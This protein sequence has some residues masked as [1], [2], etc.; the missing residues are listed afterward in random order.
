MKARNPNTGNFEKLYVKALDSM[1]IG[2][3]VDFD[4]SVSDIPD[5]W[6]EVSGTNYTAFELYNNTS[7]TT[8][9]IQLSDSVSNYSYIEILY[10]INVLPNICGNSCI[11][12]PNVC[13]RAILFTSIP[14]NAN[15]STNVRLIEISGTSITNVYENYIN[16][17]GSTTDTNTS[18]IK[19]YKV[20]GY[21]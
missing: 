10:F 12:D 11:I 17:I 18:D 13:S 5:G 20:I 9:T 14:T 2:T 1:P 15:W 3:E 6:E 8:G 19:I 4:G 21:K 16:L 7:G